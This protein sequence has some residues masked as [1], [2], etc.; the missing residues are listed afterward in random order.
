MYRQNLI[1]SFKS[2]FRA[3]D[4]EQQYKF[5]SLYFQ[6]LFIGTLP[7]ELEEE[8]YDKYNFALIDSIE[9]KIKKHPFIFKWFFQL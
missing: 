8:N 6:S 5:L 7:T 9:R 2:A 1:S 4:N 3:K